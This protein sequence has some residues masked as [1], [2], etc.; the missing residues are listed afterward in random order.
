MINS[1][2][3]NAFFPN[4]SKTQAPLIH[5]SRRLFSEK[6]IESTSTP[7]T[8]VYEKPRYATRSNY[9]STIRSSRIGREADPN[10]G[11]TPTY[12]QRWFL[13]ITRLYRNRSE[14]PNIVP[15]PVI[16]RMHERMRIVYLI[17]AIPIFFAIFY[18]FEYLTGKKIVRDR[19]SGKVVT[20]MP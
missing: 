7:T 20:R 5:F 8:P 4:I 17:T 1:T 9:E 19:A 18:I 13:I 10:T 12:M 2:K 14:Q 11:V 6:Q 15:T 3:L 16:L